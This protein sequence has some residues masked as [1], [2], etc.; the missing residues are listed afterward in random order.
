[1]TIVVFAGPSLGS[2]EG[3]AEEQALARIHFR[4]P[5]A[6]GD[7][8]RAVRDRATA[9]GLVDGLFETTAAPWHKEILWALAEGVVVFGASSIGAIRAVELEP[10]GMHGVGRVF[11]EY[12]S[13]LLE[14]DD[15]IAVQHGPAETGYLML[16][17][18][19]VNVRATVAAACRTRV[20]D[21]CHGDALVRSAKRLFYKDRTWERIVKDAVVLGLPGANTDDLTVWLRENRVDVKRQDAVELVS[22]LSSDALSFV[23]ERKELPFV[24]TLYFERLRRTVMA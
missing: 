13:G 24:N 2:P 1:M 19:M 3:L 22:V 20:L 17:E 14:D 12:R 7:V 4:P 6:C 10:F 16:S 9:I 18:A 23:R 15:E 8:L 21:A 5:A 11:H